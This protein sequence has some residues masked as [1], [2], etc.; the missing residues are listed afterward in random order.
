M[1]IQA[2]SDLH[3]KLP[4]GIDCD[5]LLIAG[6]IC[7]SFDHSLAFQRGWCETNFSE[8]LKR[9]KYREAILIAGNHDFVFERYLPIQPGLSVNYIED[10]YATFDGLLIWGSPWSNE[11][12]GNWAFGLR[13]DE[14][15]A[16]YKMVPQGTDIIVS[17]GPPKGYG[18]AGLYGAGSTALVKCIEKVQPKLVVC[19][20]IHE[21][22][23]EY[24]LG[25]TTILNV[26]SVDKN[27]N[28]R[29]NPIWTV[30]L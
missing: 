13:E 9:Q 1:K 8:W 27:Y 26:A 12:S 23:G 3:G 6:D 4:E 15:A 30:E 22:Y 5:L 25:N 11:F 2:I 28:L 19:G 16:K 18:C 7:P 17:H 21:G 20:H 14:L 29:E 10:E 24:L